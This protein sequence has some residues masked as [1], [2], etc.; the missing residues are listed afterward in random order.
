M[1]AIFH[2]LRDA[3]YF[4]KIV[5]G[6]PE[7]IDWSMYENMSACTLKFIA[8][9]FAQVEQQLS[10]EQQ[11]RTGK[12]FIAL[13]RLGWKLFAIC[14][15]SR[16]FRTAIDALNDTDWDSILTLID[17]E[18][19]SIEI[20]ARSR[21]LD[22]RGILLPYAGDQW[23]G[24]EEALTPD[25]NLA[26]GH[27][28]HIVQTEDGGLRQPV[29]P[30]TED[31]ELQSSM[32][33]N[34]LHPSFPDETAPAGK[35]NEN[36]R[37]C[38]LCLKNT[39]KC[40]PMFVP[41]DFIELREYAD[42]GVGTRALVNFPNNMCLGEFNGVVMPKP[43]ESDIWSME[44]TTQ[45]RDEDG[46]TCYKYYPNII[47]DPTRLG[48]W[49]RYSNHHCDQNNARPIP[50]VVGDRPFLGFIT[51]RDISVF[52]EVTITYGPNYWI[53]RGCKCGGVKC[54][55]LLKTQLDQI[56]VFI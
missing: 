25:I 18:K 27:P 39:C 14:A 40:E 2:D 20:F 32:H 15:H 46:T 24:L 38:F 16:A 54:V 22:W 28:H 12:F 3:C 45:K 47:V 35:R 6:Q 53:G 34:F 9:V 43:L 42:K 17:E 7:Q 19:R 37:K 33:G 44:W 55:S 31:G 36:F 41:G 48:S 49:T 1:S 10:L 52:E 30:W 56:N 8:E 21:D 11:N 5:Q 50:A 29:F 23:P 26:T 13:G 4:P 51:L